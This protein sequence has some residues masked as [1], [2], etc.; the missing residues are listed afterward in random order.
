MPTFRAFHFKTN[1][2]RELPSSDG[3]I[4]KQVADLYDAI[5]VLQAA[6]GVLADEVERLRNQA[7]RDTTT[8]RSEI[9]RAA[10]K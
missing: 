10:R 4:T 3:P 5:G 6:I 9:S 7:E 2:G 1:L 8:L